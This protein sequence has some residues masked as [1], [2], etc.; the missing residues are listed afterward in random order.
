MGL[1]CM[2]A[3]CLWLCVPLVH[4]TEASLIGVMGS[5]ALLSINGGP[6]VGLSIGE[7]RDGVKLLS[8]QG[9]QAQV[10]IDGQKRFLRAG[11]SLAPSTNRGEEP[12]VLKADPRGHFY[13][14]GQVNN[15]PLRMMVDTGASAL[16]L[17]PSDAKR[18]GLDYLK[19]Q[20]IGLQTANGLARGYK[21]RIDRLQIGSITVSG[22]EAVVG[23]ADMPIALLG[24]SVLNRMEM[25]RS[26][27]TMTLKKRY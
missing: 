24:M 23:A 22:V 13:V 6:T 19:G 25:Q 27:D 17:G 16:S 11:D 15:A 4:A 2:S 7:T 3:I 9:D 10:L 1:N 5:R 8:L 21:I 26:G 12:L 14:D 20:A 18:L